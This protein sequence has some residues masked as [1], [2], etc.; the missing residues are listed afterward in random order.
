MKTY[1]VSKIL[2]GSTE[3][4]I[5]SKV[6]EVTEDII[7]I[8]DLKNLNLSQLTKLAWAATKVIELKEAEVNLQLAQDNADIAFRSNKRS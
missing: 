1:R 8:K 2:K 6:T 7:D 4:N 3:L 5:N